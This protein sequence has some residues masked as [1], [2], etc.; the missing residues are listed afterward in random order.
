MKK[1]LFVA[2]LPAMI[3]AGSSC[4]KSK[5]TVS[6]AQIQIGQTISTATPLCGAIKGTFKADST[7]TVTCDITVNAGDTVLI[8]KGV[9]IK[10]TN[11][12]AF[13]VNGTFISLGL[14]GDPVTITDP[15]KV[16]TTGP[17]IFHQDSAYVGGW[18]G[19]YCG[20]T[21]KLFV[22]KWTHLDFAGAGLKSIPFTGP[23]VGN[24]YV[25]Y[26]GNPS[27][28]FILEDSWIYGSNDDAVRFYGGHINVM[29]NTCEKLGGNGGDGFNAKSGTQG[30]MAYNMFIGCATNGT[31]SANDGGVNPECMITMYNNTYVNGGFRNNGVYGARAGCAEV[32]NQSKALV[33]NN[34]IVNC[35]FGYRIAGGNEATAKVYHADTTSN[36]GDPIPQTA[37]GYN[38]MY[39]DSVDLANQ[40]VPTNVTQSVITHPQSTDIPDMKTFLGTGYTYGAI[41]D[42]S[43]L[44]GKNNPMFKNYPLPNVNFRTQA[45]IDGYDFHLQSGSPA[46]GKGY[47]GFSP[48]TNVPV[49][50]NFGSSGITPPGKDLGC[51]QTD[52]TGNQ[53]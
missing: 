27:G 53:H 36:S 26:Y 8:Q 12:A 32:E 38:L 25:I 23:S 22:C 1:L 37:Y 44:V 43:S 47:T 13:V 46:I 49:D 30:N 29:R 18:Q 24:N 9:T 15:S 39:A 33:Y 40:F 14:P 6:A 10:M 52:G 50:P 11:T 34:I 3:F 41:Y 45:S 21:C 4:K 28:N 35:Y 7:Y 19:I 31:K 20:P 42:G 5:S 51:Y 16:K 17:S 2:I 48:I